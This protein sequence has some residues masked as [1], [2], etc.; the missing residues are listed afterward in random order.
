MEFKEKL[1][2]RQLFLLLNKQEINVSFVFKYGIR[3]EGEDLDVL[4]FKVGVEDVWLDI[5]Y[6]LLVV[7][8]LVYLYCLGSLLII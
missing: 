6:I 1:L 4:R 7:L 3:R 8:C 2:N 5:V